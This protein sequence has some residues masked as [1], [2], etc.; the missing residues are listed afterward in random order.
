MRKSSN[1]ATRPFEGTAVELTWVAVTVGLA[2]V[3]TH[4]VVDPKYAAL[5]V[6]EERFELT[7]V[8]G[9]QTPTRLVP[10]PIEGTVAVGDKDV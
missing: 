4:G 7:D 9:H 2:E 10:A 3:P 1:E 6:S 5:P 8:F